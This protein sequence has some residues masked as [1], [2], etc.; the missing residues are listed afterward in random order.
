MQIIEENPDFQAMGNITR[1]LE[2]AQHQFTQY[3]MES[4]KVFSKADLVRLDT[5]SPLSH[6]R[7]HVV[8]IYF[9]A[10]VNDMQSCL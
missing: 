8:N 4:D 10:F 6:S 5:T 1:F 9:V 3:G 7:T 2:A